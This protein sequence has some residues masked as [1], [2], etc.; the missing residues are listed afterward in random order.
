MRTMMASVKLELRIFIF[1]EM[2]RLAQGTSN[3]QKVFQKQVIGRSPA[4]FI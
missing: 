2:V 1:K 3:Q 4:F